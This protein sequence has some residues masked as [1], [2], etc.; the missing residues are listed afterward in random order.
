MAWYQVVAGSWRGNAKMEEIA[1]QLAGAQWNRVWD[2]LTEQVWSMS[3]HERRGYIRARGALLV[4]EAVEQ[5]VRQRQMQPDSVAGL[6]V[7]AMEH[8]VS[9]VVE[10]MSTR[11]FQMQR[12]RRAA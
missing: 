6:Y 5:A 10:H 7:R 2:R 3:R 1:I 8:V 12:V 11:Q 9:R 4:Q